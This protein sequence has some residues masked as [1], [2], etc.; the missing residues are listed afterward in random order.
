GQLR[1]TQLRLGPSPETDRRDFVTIRDD[2]QD[3]AAGFELAP[4][5]TSTGLVRREL[6]LVDLPGLDLR[7]GPGAPGVEG[8]EG[9]LAGSVRG[10]CVELLVRQRVGPWIDPLGEQDPD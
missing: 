6:E 1:P 7:E 9:I 8:L 2:D 10:L 5:V 3:R 4:Q